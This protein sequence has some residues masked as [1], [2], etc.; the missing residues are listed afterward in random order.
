[1]GTVYKEVTV[2]QSAYVV[3]WNYYFTV[4]P[5]VLTFASGGET[6]YVTVSSYRQKL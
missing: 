3:T 5:S 4:S 2:T 6:K 1:M